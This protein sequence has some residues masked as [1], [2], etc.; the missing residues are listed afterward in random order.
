[1]EVGVPILDEKLRIQIL[2]MFHIMMSDCVKARQEM[3]DG[4]YQKVKS[5][6][7]EK[8]NSQEYFYEQ[9]YRQAEEKK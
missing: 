6:D 2:E 7:G 5:G 1:M 4:I 3:D 8:I 9:A